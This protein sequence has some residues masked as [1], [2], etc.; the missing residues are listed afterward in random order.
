[1]FSHTSYVQHKSMLAI[2][3]DQLNS[4]HRFAPVLLFLILSFVGIWL[5]MF[6]HISAYLFELEFASDYI[7]WQRFWWG[8]CQVFMVNW[9]M[10]LK[11]KVYP[12]FF[13]PSAISLPWNA[14]QIHVI[15][16]PNIRDIFCQANLARTGCLHNAKP[17]TFKIFWHFIFRIL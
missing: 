9:Q 17:L 3:A 6:C 15:N 14:T 5:Q 2:E 4:T 8:L 10:F 12:F 1:M 7:P 13:L 16:N 11:W